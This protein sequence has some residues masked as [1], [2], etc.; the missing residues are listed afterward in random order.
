MSRLLSALR[1]GAALLAGLPGVAGAWGSLILLEA[2]PAEDRLALGSSYWA[3]PRSP[4]GR[5]DSHALTPAIDYYRHD[6]GFASTET[7]IGFNVSPQESWQAGLR[8]WP[9]WGWAKQDLTPDQSRLGLRLQQQA[10]ANALLGGVV[11]AQ[12][13]VSRGS[14]QGHDG[15]QTEL[16]L[17]SG[18]PWSSGVLGFGVAATYGNRAYRRDY[19]QVDAAGWSDWSWTLS[20]EQKLGGRWHADAQLQRAMVLRSG[21]AVD[22][23][24]AR[25]GAWHPSALL[26]SLWRD[27]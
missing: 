14:G 12:S 16:G 23:V 6:G 26:V 25:R 21:A 10:F 20:A 24:A 5:H 1:L 19:T 27:W 7:G 2:P 8:L 17:S 15:L 18:L 13:A 4:D 11:L 9:Q 22:A 3:I